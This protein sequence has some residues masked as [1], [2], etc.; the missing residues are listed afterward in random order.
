MT[1]V[2]KNNNKCKDRDSRSVQN[3]VAIRFYELLIPGTNRAITSVCF[4][5]IIDEASITQG[6]EKVVIAT[7]RHHQDGARNDIYVCICV[8]K[9]FW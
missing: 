2:T 6:T 3:L 8:G 5:L 7:E 1:I 9:V 4:Q